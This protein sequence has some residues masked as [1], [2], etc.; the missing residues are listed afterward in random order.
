[1]ERAPIDDRAEPPEN[2]VAQ[3]PSHAEATAANVALKE[4]SEACSFDLFALG[5]GIAHDVTGGGF[6]MY[7]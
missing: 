2:C 5:D 6:A 7:G 3:P 1:M 4:K